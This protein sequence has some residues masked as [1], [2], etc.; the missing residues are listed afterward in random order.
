MGDGE[1][2]RSEDK[3]LFVVLMKNLLLLQT[4]EWCFKRNFSMNPAGLSPFNCL[5]LEARK[6]SQITHDNLAN[7]SMKPT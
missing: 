5:L 1:M 6:P 7:G 3:V 4:H 2:I